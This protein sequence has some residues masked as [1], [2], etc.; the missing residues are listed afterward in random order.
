MGIIPLG[1]LYPCAIAGCAAP[2]FGNDADMVADAKNMQAALRAHNY[3]SLRLQ[4]DVLNDEDHL[5]VAPRGFTQG[6]KFLLAEPA[7]QPARG[8]R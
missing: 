6:L 1:Q 8:R 2:A 3:P 5:S 4:L 7:E